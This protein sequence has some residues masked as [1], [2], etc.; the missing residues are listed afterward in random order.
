MEDKKKIQAQN[1]QEETT[2]DDL[3]LERVEVTDS[4]PVT[5]IVENL[6][7][8]DNLDGIFL[9]HI[10]ITLA[11]EDLLCFGCHEQGGASLWED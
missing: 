3:L 7:L 11:V 8:G 4:S 1:R 9:S 5:H 10:G 2:Y 6:L